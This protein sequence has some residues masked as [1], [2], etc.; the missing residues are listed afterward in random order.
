MRLVPCQCLSCRK[1]YDVSAD[2]AAMNDVTHRGEWP[3]CPGCGCLAIHTPE[4]AIVP[5][6]QPLD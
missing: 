3:W 5:A 2:A 4:G 1:R 6:L